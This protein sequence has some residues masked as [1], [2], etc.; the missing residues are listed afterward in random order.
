MLQAGSFN[1]PRDADSM[2]ARLTL[3]G[4]D[5]EIKSA[6]FSNG[7]TWHRVRVGPFTSKSAMNQVESRLSQLGIDALPV[8]IQ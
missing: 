5:V 8:K 4:M 1:S 3:A 6:T 7:S 2:K